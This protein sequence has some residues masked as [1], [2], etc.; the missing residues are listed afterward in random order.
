MARES[1]GS[2]F[3]DTYDVTIDGKDYTIPAISPDGKKLSQ[4]EAIKL[5]KETGIQ[6]GQGTAPMASLA[7]VNP[8][9]F[10][11]GGSLEDVSVPNQSVGTPVPD[12]GLGAPPAG[13]PR[14]IE[15]NETPL[16]G[17]HYAGEE[18]ATDATG[19]TPTAGTESEGGSVTGEAP[20]P[21]AR[22]G[23]EYKVK[24]YPDGHFDLNTGVS[25]YPGQGYKYTVAGQDFFK[26]TGQKPVAI[27]AAHH[28]ITNPATGRSYDLAQGGKDVTPKDADFQATRVTPAQMI[29]NQIQ[30]NENTSVALKNWT[31]ASTKYE[32]ILSNVSKPFADR[33]IEDD[34]A[35]M[36]AASNIELPG[37]AMNI[38]E[39]EMSKTGGWKDWAKVQMS[40][41][42]DKPRALSDRQVTA[43]S[44]AARRAAEGARVKAEE[45]LSPFLERAKST[46]DP[47][48]IKQIV[49]ID[50]RKPLAEINPG[51]GQVSASVGAGAA[52][53][54]P[55]KP[56]VGEHIDKR[57]GKHWW[58]D[59]QGNK[60]PMN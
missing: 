45:T 34:H 2:K 32:Q 12:Q 28:Y 14:F 42:T 35:L 13:E 60:T 37:Q 22:T 47:N 19:A 44:A 24:T 7:D 4:D 39:L 6:E 40:G 11:Q 46:G 26:P 53:A 57:T 17:G 21:P 48:A 10:S 55:T 31:N 30:R 33:T 3:M 36:L 38:P 23:K 58:V 1:L 41:F 5:F 27:K 43:L 59:E 25:I 18:N 51:S 20:P 8:K 56:E 9:E 15:N 50:P 49:G 52:S 29:A 16:G 54:A